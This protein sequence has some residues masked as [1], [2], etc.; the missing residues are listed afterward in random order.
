MRNKV[1][2]CRYEEP[3]AYAMWHSSKEVRLKSSSGGAF[4]VFA[5]NV[6]RRGGVVFGAAWDDDNNVVIDY[7]ETEADL[8]RLRESK[9]VAA[10]PRDEYKKAKSFLEEGR[11]VLYCGTPCQIAGLY[12]YLRG[13]EY[14]NLTTIDFICHGAPDRRVWGKYKEYLERKFGDQITNVHFRDKRWGVE[15]N[16][17][18]KVTLRKSGVQ[19]LIYGKSNTYYYGFIHNLFMRKCCM[20]CKFNKVPRQADISL[21]DYRGL[22]EHVLFS[23]E[24]DKVLGFTGVLI[25]SPRGEFVMKELDCDCSEK[26]PLNELLDSQPLVRRSPQANPKYELFWDDFDKLSFEELEKKYLKP[27]FKYRCY[28]LARRLL[29]ANIFLRVGVIYKKLVGKRTTTWRI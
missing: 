24:R 14:N 11:E 28:I 17:L 5:E 18:L 6:I 1:G 9:Y 26:R 27:S 10:I 12:A 25:N 7:V 4:T 21:A 3:S 23:F 13:K 8:A 19:K 16:I 20:Q 22:G 29:G 15:A 2:I